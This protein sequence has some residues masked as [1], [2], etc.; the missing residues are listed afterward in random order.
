MPLKSYFALVITP[1][2]TPGIALVLALCLSLAAC[3]RAVEESGVVA[4]VNGSPIRLEE[5]EFGHDSLHLDGGEASIPSVSKLRREY[6]AILAELIIQKLVKQ[7]LKAKD[8]KVSDEEADAAEAT[9][10]GDYP[11][12]SFERMVADQYIDIGRWRDQLR[13]R[14]GV[15]KLQQA[16]LRPQTPLS[17]EEA[18]AY[19]RDHVQDFTISA[20]LRLLVLRGPTRESLERALDFYR[21]EKSPEALSQKFTQIEAREMRLK[22]DQ[23]PAMWKKPLS[24]LKPGQA[25][26]IQSNTSGFEALILLEETPA[27]VLKPAQVYTVIEKILVE[28]KLQEAFTRWLDEE[29]AKADIQISRHLL[30]RDEAGDSSQPRDEAGDNSTRAQLGNATDTLLRGK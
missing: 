13:Y 22:T 20:R 1:G 27:R 2:I 7:A 8:L 11:P 25:T 21:V 3:D 18:E 6:G 4:K 10:R 19:Y 15:E 14:L 30:P 16:V 28:Q 5:I 29:L 26:Q 23:I 12:G 24:S 17:T 9:I